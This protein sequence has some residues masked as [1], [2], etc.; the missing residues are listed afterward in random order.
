MRLTGLC[1][2]NGFSPENRVFATHLRN[3]PATAG[4]DTTV[5]CHARGGDEA[6]PR[7]FREIPGVTTEGLDTGYRAPPAEFY[8]RAVTKLPRS[9]MLRA[10]AREVT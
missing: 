10:R 2:A 5:I 1:V 3:L 7:Q 6:L 4:L 8:R 9:F